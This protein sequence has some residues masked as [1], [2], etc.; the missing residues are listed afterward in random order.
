VTS[1]GV[2]I[3][4]FGPET[5]PVTVVEWARWAEANGF[6]TIVVSDHV[7][8]TPEV[9]R[10]YPPPF[11]DPFVLLTWLAGH[12]TRVRLG[13]SVVVLPYRH[14][15]LTARVSAM[16]HI[17]SGGRFVLG[18]GAGWARTEF[19]ALGLQFADRGRMTDA[20]LDLITQAWKQEQVS[21]ELAGLSLRDVA[22]GPAPPSRHVSVW[23]GGN[24]A[25][26]I[27]RAAR[28]ADAWHPQ[29][30]EMSWLV[31]EGLPLLVTESAAARRTTPLLVPRI[32]PGCS[33]GRRI[34]H[35]HRVS[36]LW[37]RS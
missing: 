36:D 5:N 21:A 34:R 31:N 14:P 1:F 7:A 18:V 19:A 17:L 16:I 33:I 29:N 28:F 22:T 13:T 15:L 27:R 24:S 8:L 6:S 2:N 37:M 32:K 9:T 23:V 3:P 4:N 11:Y 35:A 25:A 20:Y 12:T 30:P 10:V 26:A